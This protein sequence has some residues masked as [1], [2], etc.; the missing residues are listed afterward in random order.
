VSPLDDVAARQ[1][2]A[3]LVGRPRH[4]T[5]PNQSGT[6]NEDRRYEG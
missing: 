5:I 6:T 4:C 2:P 3:K 1:P